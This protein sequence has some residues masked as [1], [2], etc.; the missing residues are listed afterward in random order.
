VIRVGGGQVQPMVVAN[1]T[2]NTVTVRAT[3]N[4]MNII[5]RIVDSNDNPRA[6]VLVDVQILEVN[7]TGRSGIS[8]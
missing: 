7:R 6:E 3:T 8:P 4:V 5:E 1:K 2:A